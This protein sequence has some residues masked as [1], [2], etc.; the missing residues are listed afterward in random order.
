MRR[1][2]LFPLVLWPA[3]CAGQIPV[4][5]VSPA[6]LAFTLDGG[7]AVAPLQVRVRNLGSGVLRW[8]ARASDSWIRVSPAS[9]S[10]RAV[11]TVAIEGARLSPGRHEGRITVDAPDADDSPAVVTVIVD[12]APASTSAAPRATAPAV[13]PVKEQPQAGAAKD[14]QAGGDRAANAVPPAAPITGRLRI[15]R[16]TL[17]PATRNL[18]Y[19]Q[20][21]PVAG[22]MP[23]YTLRIVEGRLPAGLVLAY[24]AVSG[25][26]RVQGYYPFVMSVTDASSP[27]VT[28]VQPLGLRVIIL[29]PDTALV[30]SPPAISLRLASRSRNGRAALAVASGRQRL[31]WTAAADV[32]WIRLTPG[33]GLSP[34]SVEI[35]ILADGLAPGAHLGTVTVT[36]EGAPN[37]PASVPVQVTVPR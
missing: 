37:S 32:P 14:A 17:P 1:A 2:C 5:H 10:G 30:V 13:G 29:Q 19:A 36:M 34:S 7:A 21:I 16:A 20:A 33:A 9:G 12:V 28:I 3:I 11:M 35:T 24:G 18:P 31:E 23:P 4:L 27:P 6:S 8:T 15:D 26:A 25:T 22:G